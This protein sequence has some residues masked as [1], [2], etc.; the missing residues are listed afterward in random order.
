MPR[1]ALSGTL[2]SVMVFV[3]YNLFWAMM[4]DRY[5]ATLGSC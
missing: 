4:L 3:G 1:A 2:R 5:A